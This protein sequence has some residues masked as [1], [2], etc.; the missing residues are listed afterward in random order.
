M[1]SNP[2]VPAAATETRSSTQRLNPAAHA[3]VS[4]MFYDIGLSVIAY[5][6]A[7]LLGASTYIALLAGTVVAGLRMLWVALRQRTLDP[8]ALFLLALFGAGLV[9]SFTTGDPRFILAKDSSGSLTA[10]VVLVGSCLIDRP[11]AYY[12]AQ[13]FA[14]AGGAA[15]QEQFRA[16]GNTTAMRARWFRISL[17]WGIALLIDASLRIAAIYMLPITMAANVSQ[18]LMVTVFGLLIVWTLRS[19]RKA[20]PAARTVTA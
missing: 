9:L 12:A 5:F 19:A 2:S 16:T 6:L 14:R 20:Q 1:T 10:G 8:F 18:I 3:M 11:L 15:M 13:R 17:V 4:T 7:E